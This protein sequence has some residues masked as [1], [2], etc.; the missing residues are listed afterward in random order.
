MALLR[1]STRNLAGP[2]GLILREDW[3]LND[4]CEHRWLHDCQC[5]QTI[6]LATHINSRF[7][8][9]H[10]PVFT[11]VILAPST[12]TGAII[13]PTQMENAWLTGKQRKSFP[14]V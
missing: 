11:P 9:Y 5:L 14:L 6:N 4:V 8:C 3:Q 12:L 13:T 2:C 7:K 10:T 1:L